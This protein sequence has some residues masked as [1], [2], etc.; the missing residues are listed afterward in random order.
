MCVTSHTHQEDEELPLDCSESR[1]GRGRIH[2]HQSGCLLPSRDSWGAPRRP[3]RCCRS[4]GSNLA[5]P[6]PSDPVSFHSPLPPPSS[7]ERPAIS[8]AL[9]ASVLPDSDSLTIRSFV[10]LSVA[11]WTSRQSSM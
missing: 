4:R 5:C 9:C 3:S 2:T 10:S 7:M 11:V 1:G 8:A 6:L